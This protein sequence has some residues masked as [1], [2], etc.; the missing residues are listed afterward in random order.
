M[1]NR[2]PGLAIAMPKG[3]PFSPAKP[4]QLGRPTLPLVSVVIPC[5]HQAEYLP[6]AIDSVLSQT[7]PDWELVVVDDGS[8]D[9]TSAV[10]R[11]YQAEHPDRAII[12]IQQTNRGVSEAR[13]AGIAASH[14]TYI[15]PLDADDEIAETMLEETCAVL[16]QDPSVG[17]VYTDA[18]HVSDGS[19][20]VVPAEDFDPDRECDVNQPN[21]CALYQR[22]LWETVGGYNPN[23]R[24][25][26]EDWDFWLSCVDRGLV[27]RRMA[28]PLFRYR[29]HEGTRS[30]GASRHHDELRRQMRINHPTLYTPTRRA[31]R[32]ANRWISRAVG[33]LARSRT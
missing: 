4:G 28:R 12:L 11:R 32:F 2:P 19:L 16:D 21:Y 1:A 26:Y 22:S 27:G 18:I 30:S 14:G 5:F 15:L 10:A 17:F 31:R 29:A 25:G 6:A 9:D 33:R 23:M 8:P 7:L 24:S 3:D 13:N 20:R